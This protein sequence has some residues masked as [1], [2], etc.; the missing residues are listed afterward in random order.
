MSRFDDSKAFSKFCTGLNDLILERFQLSV[1]FRDLLYIKSLWGDSTD[2]AINTSSSIFP[3]LTVLYQIFLPYS[4]LDP[5]MTFFTDLIAFWLL[6]GIKTKSVQ[7][8]TPISI[9]FQN[10]NLGL[11][12]VR[13]WDICSKWREHDLLFDSSSV[14]ASWG[15]GWSIRRGLPLPPSGSKALVNWSRGDS[16]GKHLTQLLSVSGGAEGWGHIPDPRLI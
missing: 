7:F 12:W 5:L 6:L 9:L 11:S 14:P 15:R 8:K 1:N 4:V 13:P 10:H 2:W 3:F 16:W